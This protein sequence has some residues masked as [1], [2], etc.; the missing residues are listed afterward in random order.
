MRY[1]SP[2][3][4]AWRYSED[5]F[6]VIDR[7]FAWGADDAEFFAG[8]PGYSGAPLHVTGNPRIDLLR[9]EVRGYFAP[10]VEALKRRYGDFILVNT[11][12]SFVN[13]FVPALNLIQRDARPAA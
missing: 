8:Y 2:E 7:V 10:E 9:P 13:N 11:N 6:K 12:F 1:S 5:T 3:Y 4:Y